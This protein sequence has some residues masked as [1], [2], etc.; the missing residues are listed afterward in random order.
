MSERIKI[1]HIGVNGEGVAKTPSGFV[2]VPFT[3]VGEV[4]TIARD[5]AYGTLMG[6]VDRSSERIEPVCRH[7]EDCGGCLLQHW[8]D[9]GYQAWKRSLVVEALKARELKTDVDALIAAAPYQRRRVTLSARVTP[10]GQKVGFNGLRSHD[11]VEIQECPIAVSEIVAAFADLR[12][13]AAPLANNAKAFH[14]MVTAA[15]NGL[16][17]A[18][19]GVTITNE[20]QRQKLIAEVLARKVLR[21]TIEGEIIVEKEKP[22]IHLGNAV[23]EIPAGVFLQAT[24]QAEN[25]MAALALEGLKKAQN[26]A[27][28]FS[29]VGSF[30]FPLAEKM[31][32]HAVEFDSAALLALDKAARHAKVLKKLT[33]ERRDLFR[34]PLSAKE[35]E[36]YDGVLFDPPRAGAEE[37]ARE[38]AKSTV[39]RVVAVSCNPVTLARDLK[40]LSDGGY[41]LER[42]VPIDQFLWSPHVETVAFLSKRKPKPGWKL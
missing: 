42:V 5:G 17:V 20:K 23:V 4:A 39:S 29:G 24:K 18:F 37:Q 27:D 38:I 26:V 7:F 14:I 36:V 3:L 16:D 19:S 22:R 40:I 30:T 32:V 6:I 2:Q 21:L 10:K 33:H 9:G 15:D 11:V 31:N 41:K 34:R 25:T 13:L 35:L 28:L 12:I 8:Q 1:D